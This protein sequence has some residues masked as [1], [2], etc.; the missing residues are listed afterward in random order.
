MISF[1]GTFYTI[2]DPLFEMTIPA[3]EGYGPDTAD[4]AD[5]T[6]TFPDGSR[7]YAT[8]MTVDVI[9]KVID[10]NARTGESLGGRYFW[11]SDLIIIRNVGFEEMA[12]AIR[13]LI[14]SGDIEQACGLLAPLDH[15]GD[16]QRSSVESEACS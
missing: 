14:E 1:D 4:E 5:V 15:A 2:A 3:W 11:C 10:K 16:R 13:D 9:Q 12:A 8:F 7:R 6:I